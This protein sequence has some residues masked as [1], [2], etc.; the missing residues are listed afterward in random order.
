MQERNEFVKK[1]GSLK[2]Y[3]GKIQTRMGNSTRNANNKKSTKT[4]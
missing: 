1:L 3:E 2:K 4:G